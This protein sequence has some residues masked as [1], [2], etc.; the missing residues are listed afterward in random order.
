M[1]KICEYVVDTNKAIAKKN[2]ISKKIVAK[3]FFEFFEFFFEIMF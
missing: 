1:N 2:L 3:F